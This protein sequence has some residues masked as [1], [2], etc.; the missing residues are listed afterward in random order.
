MPKNSRIPKT[1]RDNLKFVYLGIIILIA[2]LT[3]LYHINSPL[4]DWHSWRQADTAAV[5]RNFTRDGINLLSPKFDDLGNVQS[6]KYN[7]EGYRMVEFPI[8]NSIFAFFYKSMPVLSLEIF[9]RL[10]TIFSSLIL[11]SIIYLIVYTLE[12]RLAA[13]LTAFFFAIMPFFVYYSRVILPD[14]TALTFMFLSLFFIYQWWQGATKKK[15]NT[16]FL[17]S[18]LFSTLSLLTK[19]TTIFFLLAIVY[20]FYKKMGLGFL[21]KISFYMFIF[22][23]LLPL[24]LWRGWISRFPE[25]IP[26][27]EWL[28]TSVNTYEGVKNIFFRPAFFRWI[29]YER[30]SNLI[31]GGYLVVFFVIGILKKPKKNYFLHIILVAAIIYLFTFQGG[32][33]QHDYY[34][35]MILPALAIFAGIGA[36]TLLTEIRIFPLRILNILVCILITLFSFAFSFYQVKNYYSSSDELVNIANIIKTLT[37]KDAQIVTDRDGDTTLLYLA[38]RKGLPSVPEDL[39]L[40]KAR[41]MKYFVTTKKD[42]AENVKKKYDLVFENQQ[43]FIFK[44]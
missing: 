39:E 10:T 22:L 24:L 36:A 26:V 20:I 11:I 15:S 38:D 21:K 41:N 23:S 33:V 27:S 12:A 14:M 44:L 9:G 17:L 16:F 32:N 37:E 4:T 19:P 25:G 7:P 18:L 3:R 6:G 31:L 30:I 28:F 34:Q 8:Y 13:I 35:I 29:F 2:T 40:L 5:A 42:V 1:Y 43:V